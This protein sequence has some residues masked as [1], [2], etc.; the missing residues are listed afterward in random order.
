VKKI[1]PFPAVPGQQHLAQFGLNP[2]LL[3]Y[4]RTYFIKQYVYML[5]GVELEAD[6][7]Q[8]RHVND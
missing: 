8:S 4:L 6:D 1:G 2:A 7:W 5:L 3:T